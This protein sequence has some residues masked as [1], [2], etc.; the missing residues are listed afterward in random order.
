MTFSSQ[1]W[2]ADYDLTSYENYRLRGGWKHLQ[3][4]TCR[5]KFQ[6]SLPDVWDEVCRCTVPVLVRV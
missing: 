6:E 1:A 5:N 2:R 4:A 3:F